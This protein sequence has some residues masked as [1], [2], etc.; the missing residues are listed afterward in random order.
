MERWDFL[1]FLT[2]TLNC[3]VTI[4]GKIWLIF[5]L[6]LRMVVI[7]LAGYPIY[8]DEQ[9]R[10]VCN[11]LQPGCSNVCYDMFSPVSH[12]RFWLIHNVSVLLP[13]TMFSI[14]VLHKG[15]LHAARGALQPD[16]C[17]GSHSLSGQ[18][19]VKGLYPRPSSSHL[20]VPDFSTA[21]IIQLL[22]R[23]LTEA[24]FAGAQYYLFGFWV[25][26]QFSCYHSP[27]TSMVDCYIS[28]PTEKSIMMLFIWGVNALSFLLSFVDLL[29]CM[30]RWLRQKHLAK[31]VIKNACV[32]EEHDSPNMSLGEAK[33][34][35]A[36][37][38]GPESP[39]LVKRSSQT[40]ENGGWPESRGEED[41][42]L[43]SVV[44]PKDVASRSNLNSPGNKSCSSGRIPFLDEDGS[45]VMSTGSEQQGIA[46]KQL[47]GR[48]IEEMAQA[49]RPKDSPHLGEL[50]SAPRSRL[51][52]HY[53]S[54]E[55]KLSTS[56]VSCG[57]PSH[58]RAKKSEWV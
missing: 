1:G 7:I 5:T 10:F 58:R 17:T 40:S 15:T 57:S 4:V 14:Y 31:Q 41:V 52:G 55:L 9:E 12:F 38:V 19:A 27:C 47:Q 6:M 53:S 29:F 24:A 34:C 48:P 44:W 18:K 2:I 32:S 22:L 21:Y 8:Q 56:Q 37:E 23:I 16:C 28:R 45:E 51:G 39:R 50:V 54:R 25:P 26:K 36:S 11:T 13:Y 43:H 49:T 3:N 46:P 20:N 33:N 35:L 42:S 30:Q